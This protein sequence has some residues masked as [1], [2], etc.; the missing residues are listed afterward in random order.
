MFVNGVSTFIRSNCTFQQT[1]INET[2][3]LTTRETTSSRTERPGR[4]TKVCEEDSTPALAQQK[5]LLRNLRNP[6]PH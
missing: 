3:P 1:F 6:F 4:S 2:K 5:Q